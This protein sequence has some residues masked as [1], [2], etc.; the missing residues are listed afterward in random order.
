MAGHLR[1]WAREL[2]SPLTLLLVVA[3]VVGGVWA[4]V[5]LTPDQDVEV[6]GQ[7]LSVGA[8]APTATVSGPPRI[9]QIGNTSLDV[10]DVAIY[11]PL[12]PQLT[13]GPVTAQ[14][15]RGRRRGRP[16]AGTQPG[17][18]A[19]GDRQ[20]LRALVR[21]GDA[22]PGRGRARHLRARRLAARA[23]DAAVHRAPLGCRRAARGRRP[24]PLADAH[25][26]DGGGAR[27]GP[28]RVG[29]QRR[30]GGGRGPGPARRPL[31]HRPHRRPPRH[32]VAGGAHRVRGPGRGDRGLA[33]RPA[34]RTGRPGRPRRGRRV[35]PQ[36]RL[37]RPPES[38]RR[39]ATRCS[40]S[41][42]RARAS[43]RACAVR[44]RRAGWRSRRRSGGSSRSRTRRS[45]PSPSAP[46][47]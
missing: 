44:S 8:Q 21:L 46:T 26:L 15:D 19:L 45:W 17:G 16:R 40:T 29:R 32:P 35:R 25:A 39:S 9:V 36:H 11:G 47:T 31:A 41:P 10:P 18:R 27:R 12:R 3:C 4:A 33:G 1:G 14:R 7:Q 38:R 34:R 24:A 22:D 37:A 13:I 5:V 6:L 30:A 20:R 42:A 23:R 28:G 43:P 2:R